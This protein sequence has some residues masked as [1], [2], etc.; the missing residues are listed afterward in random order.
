[1]IFIQIKNYCTKVPKK[2]LTAVAAFITF[3]KLFL[4]SLILFLC[5]SDSCLDGCACAGYNLC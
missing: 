4:A 5:I 3:P 1:M 2:R